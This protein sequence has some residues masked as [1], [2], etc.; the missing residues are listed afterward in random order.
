M[1]YVLCFGLWVFFPRM[2]CWSFAMKLSL[3]EVYIR[4]TANITPSIFY[5]CDI[6][7]QQQQLKTNSV[8]IHLCIRVPAKS[9]HTTI[10]CWL[11]HNSC[12]SLYRY[13]VIGQKEKEKGRNKVK[14]LGMYVYIL[15]PYHS[16][17]L[18]CSPLFFLH[19]IMIY[20]MLVSSIWIFIN[21]MC[22]MHQVFPIPN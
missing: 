22:I 6:V 20:F 1:C 14:V 12:R 9:K 11:N 7:N 2:F 17:G 8:D 18:I 10:G 15:T 21:E 4:R 3:V 13:W 19:K 16:R 5:L